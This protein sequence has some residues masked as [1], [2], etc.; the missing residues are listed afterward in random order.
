MEVIQWIAIL[1]SIQGTLPK[2]W[3]THTHNTRKEMTHI[4][5]PS[6]NT[7]THGCFVG[8]AWVA[9]EVQERA[10]MKR[11]PGAMGVAEADVEKLKKSNRN[12]NAENDA[13][14]TSTR[15]Q[16]PPGPLGVDET[17]ATSM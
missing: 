16:M 3:N 4:R 5:S 7:E 11:R 12:S 14:M 9:F 10:H 8:D 13:P 2:E 15:A 1:C 17:L 6:P